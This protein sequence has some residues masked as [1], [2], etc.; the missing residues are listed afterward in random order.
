MI[1]SLFIRSGKPVAWVAKI[2]AQIILFVSGVPH[3]V[4]GLEN[5]DPG[6]EYIFISNHESAFDIFLVLASLPYQLVFMVKLELRKI[7]FMGWA[8]VMGRHIFVNRKNHKAALASLEIARESLKKYPRSIM[9]FPEGSRSLDGHMK[10]FKKGGIILGI[11]TNHP[12]VPMAICGTFDVI[13]KGALYISRTPI[14]LIIGRPLNTSEYEYNDRSQ[15]TE[16]L[17]SEIVNLKSSWT[18]E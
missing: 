9:I 6:K 15:V 17:H 3:F 13:K 16:I 1:L 14:R 5:L 10:P 11:Q 8:L 12:I 4:D 7:P 18:A 2:W